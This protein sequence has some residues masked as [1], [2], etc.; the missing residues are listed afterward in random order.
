V[1]Y[2]RLLLDHLD[3]I[4]RI[5]RSIG[6]RRHLSAVEQDDYASFVRLRLVED[7]YAVLRK[8]QGRST[9]G[10]YLSAVFE[11]LALDFCN[12]LWGRW[13]PSA[14]AQKL[15]A[16]AITLE[17]LTH[18]DGYSIEEAIEIVRSRD[19]GRPTANELRALWA[20]LP[21]RPRTIEMG[22]DAAHAVLSSET[23]DERIEDEARKRDT[24]RLEETLKA[25]FGAMTARDRLM[26]ALRFDEGLAVAQIAKVLRSSTATVHRRIDRGLKD[27]RAALARA[28]FEARD[29]AALIGGPNLALSPLLRAE[30]EKFPRLVRLF[31]RDG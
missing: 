19:E 25:A 2:E 12:E 29:I 17:R 8:F 15:G 21:V 11:R 30:I 24:E 7:D 4:E 9:L 31:K 3:L 5:V 13:R 28:G 20:Q 23:S 10:T 14:M 16:A 27:L 6:R 1:D 26:I 22:E 18:R